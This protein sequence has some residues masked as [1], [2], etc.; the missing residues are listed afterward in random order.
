MRDDLR[1]PLRSPSAPAA[2]TTPW[3]NTT[4]ARKPRKD[5]LRCAA[6]LMEYYS[7]G[8]QW[9]DLRNPTNTI[10]TRD[11]LALVTVWIKGDPYVVVD[12]CLRMLTPRELA[13]AM[14]F[15]PQ[16]VITH[17]AD[18]RVFTKSQQVHMIGNAVPPLLQQ[19]VTAANFGDE[20]E[21]MLEAA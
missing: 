19:A 18:G 9:S 10:T 11:R 7:E 2:H 5:A 17:G 14:S 16:Y 6:F 4:S 13:N 1:E 3:S 20:P 21:R 12:I 15:P 8:G